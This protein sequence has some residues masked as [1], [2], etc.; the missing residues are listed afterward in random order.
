M[1]NVAMLAVL[2]T[3]VIWSARAEA[4]VICREPPCGYYG[5]RQICRTYH[6]EFGPFW[7]Y[8]GYGW[9]YRYRYTEVRRGWTVSPY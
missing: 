4:G 1:R 6:N 5:C 2:G 7:A 9:P 3:C 8:S